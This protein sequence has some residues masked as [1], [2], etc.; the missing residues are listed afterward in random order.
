MIKISTTIFSFTDETFV[1]SNIS[2]AA[3]SDSS[4]DPLLISL[5]IVHSVICV[6]GMIGNGLV[7]YITG[8][9]MKKTVN[10]IYFLNLAVADFIFTFFLIFG[11]ISMSQNFN[12]SHGEFMCKFNSFMISLNIFASIFLLTAISLDRCLSTWVIVWV[13]NKRTV[14]KAKVCCFFIWLI[15]IGCSVPSFIYHE[16][17]YNESTNSTYCLPYMPKYIIIFGF[18]VG[19]LIP[20]IIITGSYL[21]IGIRVRRLRQK[22][23][24][25]FKVIMV[26]VLAFYFCCL[27]YNIYIII[28]L[29]ANETRN[30]NKEI[31]LDE[32]NKI[33]SYMAPVVIILGCLNSCLNPF[34]YV[35]MC[36]DFKT[37]LRQSLVSVFEGAFAESHL[38]LQTSRNPP[39][40]LRPH[41]QIVPEDNL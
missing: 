33:L 24:K 6:V 1:S 40:H 4:T 25:P 14:F 21:A 2:T 35:F 37:K 15:S 39:G 7:I 8:F 28:E 13:Q 18:T 5:I 19:F 11:I 9:K 22:T 36:E 16:A 41:P 3:S 31:N 30:K 10:T 29:W 23:M 20:A 32:L 17:R 27:P 34:L 38:A 12:W 26:V